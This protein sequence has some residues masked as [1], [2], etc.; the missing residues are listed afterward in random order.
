LDHRFTIMN[1]IKKLRK[2]RNEEG[3]RGG[4]IIVSFFNSIHILYY[5]CPPMIKFI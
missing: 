3:G 1:H 5:E 4:Q 2:A